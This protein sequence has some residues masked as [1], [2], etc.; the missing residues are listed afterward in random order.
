MSS[1][2]Y[3]HLPN[4]HREACKANAARAGPESNDAA[5]RFAGVS[6]VSHVGTV[7]MEYANE[8]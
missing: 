3:G 6:H 1:N 7:A 5:Q 4:G 2:A 8:T